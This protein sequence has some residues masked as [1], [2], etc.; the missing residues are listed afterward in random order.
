MKKEKKE[1]L[2]MIIPIVLFI[3]LISFTL[4]ENQKY[5]EIIGRYDRRSL[6]QIEEELHELV[7][8][9]ENNELTDERYLEH[10]RNIKDINNLFVG[11]SP[12]I[13]F[14]EYDIDRFMDSHSKD[15]FIINLLEYKEFQM[16]LDEITME[17][18]K[19]SE[20]YNYFNN[21][22]NREKILE[23]LKINE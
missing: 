21:N 15:E 4:I 10:R 1:K 7:Y 17:Y 11:I 13:S 18:K 23:Y 12:I 16:R 5:R 6:K 22:K 19:G 3:F 14:M 9:A 2:K 8:Y 20:C